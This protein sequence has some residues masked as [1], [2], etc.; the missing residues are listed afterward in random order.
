[1]FIRT[2]VFFLPLLSDS[3]DGT[4][5][6]TVEYSINGAIQYLSRFSVDAII[7]AVILVFAIVF[8]KGVLP[9]RP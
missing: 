9:V 6:Y 8:E 2:A 7:F 1:M 4:T 3:L 5:M